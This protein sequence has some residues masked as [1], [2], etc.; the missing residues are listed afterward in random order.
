MEKFEINFVIV[1]GFLKSNHSCNKIIFLWFPVGAVGV[2]CLLFHIFLLPLLLVF[3]SCS[4]FNSYFFF[5]LPFYSFSFSLPLQAIVGIVFKQL[6]L[7][8][9]PG[10]VTKKFSKFPLKIHVEW[11]LTAISLISCFSQSPRSGYS[12]AFV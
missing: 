9:P 12:L 1:I 4:F 10:K 11:Y 8:I 5:S 3:T 7:T 6:T 2:F